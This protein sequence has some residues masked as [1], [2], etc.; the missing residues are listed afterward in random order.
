MNSEAA[1]IISE[2][3]STMPKMLQSPLVNVSELSSKWTKERPQTPDKGTEK[4]PAIKLVRNQK[5]HHRYVY[6]SHT[7][8]PQVGMY[9]IVEMLGINSEAGSIISEYSSTLPKRQH[10]K[11]FKII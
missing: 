10:V 2:Y 4:L 3:S 9:R 1:S 7:P 11:G 6:I 8:P 5:D